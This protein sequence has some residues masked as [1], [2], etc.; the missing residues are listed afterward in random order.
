MSKLRWCVVET[1]GPDLPSPLPC[2]VWNHGPPPPYFPSL[3][4][5]PSPLKMNLAPTVE[6]RKKVEMEA[7]RKVGAEAQKKKEAQRKAGAETHRKTE[8]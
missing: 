2:V 1:G 8:V 7:P 5:A 3:V 4:L 6:V